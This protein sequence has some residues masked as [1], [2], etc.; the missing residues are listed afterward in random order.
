MSHASELIA[1]DIDAYLAEHERKDL[2]RLLTCGS[3]DDGKS[4]LIGR[5]LHDSKMIYEDQLA[6]LAVDSTTSGTQ[7][8]E[9]DLALL[10]DGLKAEREQGITIDVA[11][12]YFS[13]ARRKF[14]IAD[15]PGHE[16]YT[17]NMA[18]GASNCQL[19]VIL[20]DA[21]HG[22]LAQT[23]RHSYI[24][25][26]LGIRHIVVAINKMDLVDWSRSRFEEIR[27]DYRGFTESLDLVDPY[28][29][30]M[31]ALRGD[32][33]VERSEHMDWFDGPALMEHL[34][35]VDVEA[36]VDLERFRMPVQMVTRPVHDFRGFAGTIASGT[37]RPGDEVV[38]L[39]SGVRSR[40]E[41]IVTFDRDLD[42]AGPGRAVTLTLADEIDVSRGDLL[43]GPADP[44]E[45]AHDVDAMVVWMSDSPMTPGRQYLLQTSTGTSNASVT[46]IRHRVDVNTL[47]EVESESL[48]LNDIAR[49]A[50]ASDRELLYDPYRKNRT[51][52][53]FVLVDKLSNAT[54]AAGM[55]V[56]QSSSWNRA[57]SAT[58]TRQ[59]SEIT[60]AERAARF[61]QRPCTILLTGL[62]AAGKST[63]ATALERRLFDRGRTT[64]RLDGENVRMGISRDLGFSAQERSENLRR[65]AE[66]ANLVNNQGII[67]I[68]ALVA[69]KV[70]VRERARELV[71]PE[72]YV[73]V[74]VDA[75]VAVCRQRDANGMYAAADRGDIPQFPGVSATYDR[76]TDT[77]LRIDAETSEVEGAVDQIIEL[78]VERGFLGAGR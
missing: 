7:G 43:A 69:P 8:D 44:P 54:V 34:E 2:L 70:E 78:L 61:G 3:V 37:V 15:T 39:P 36:G 35:T 17:R 1:T 16:Q 56:G 72:R 9:I 76:P 38:S 32:N 42:L 27:E 46:A 10:T 52:G 59:A 6:S 45:R 60:E 51:T 47:D 25:S 57:P 14:I 49:C 63:I 73:E 13:T 48:G 62:T 33:V 22:V 26:L 50:I 65:V 41:R 21:R 28:F 66:V 30:P 75:P 29:L 40:I 31:S 18:T 67:A 77:D 11:Y 53:S 20:I 12:R 4:T 5:L 19:A 64:I 71:G 23:K 74:F 58:L 55:I 68:A 24:A